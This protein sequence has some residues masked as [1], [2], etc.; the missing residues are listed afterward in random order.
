MRCGVNAVFDDV[1]SKSI[2]SRCGSREPSTGMAGAV[3][4]R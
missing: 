4:K 2:V 1:C 3:K